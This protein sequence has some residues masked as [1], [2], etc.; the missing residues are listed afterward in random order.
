MEQT[1]NFQ[2]NQWG[3]EDPVRRE[4]FNADNLKLDTALNKAP[5]WQYGHYYGDG[6]L[7]KRKF[8][9]PWNPQLLIVQREG[10]PTELIIACYDEVIRGI[11]PVTKGFYVWHPDG[12]TD[13]GNEAGYWYRYVAFG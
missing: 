10:T 6:Q 7:T 13:S 8:D 3:P 5:R 12:A 4:D 11:W 2:L 1:T 9:T